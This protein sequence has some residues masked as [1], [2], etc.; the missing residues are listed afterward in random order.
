[1]AKLS[2]QMKTQQNANWLG[3]VCPLQIQVLSKVATNCLPHSLHKT[4]LWLRLTMQ[5][6]KGEKL[7]FSKESQFIPSLIQTQQF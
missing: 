7:Q 2:V 6:N 1:L 4:Q 5:K 3:L